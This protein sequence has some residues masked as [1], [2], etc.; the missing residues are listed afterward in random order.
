MKMK[1][2][3]DLH[4]HTDLSDGSAS[5][6]EVLALAERNNV[7]LISITDHNTLA[8]YTEDAFLEGERLGVKLLPG[9]ELDVIHGGKQ[10][11]M[12]GLGVDYKNRE[13]LEACAYNAKVQEEYNLDLLRLM[14]QDGLGVSEPDYHRYEI[15]AGRG[16]WKLLNYLLDTGVTQSLR[17]GLKYYGQY[18]FKTNSIKFISLKEAI[19][20]VRGAGGAAILAHPGEQIPCDQYASDS[21]PFWS[22]L[23]GLLMAGL[24]G[25]ECI[26]PLHGFGLQEELISLCHER[27]LY[28]SGGTDYHG[29]FFSRQKQVIGGQFVPMELVSPVLNNNIKN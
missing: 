19:D 21:S 6:Y 9:V 24:D 14:E 5:V 29:S 20:A 15:P 22:E 23:E 1:R 16:G 25:V 28:I 13:L 2:F 4:V 26:H 12:L 27:G 10:Y 18:G 11:H 7:S 3:A 17:E 8:A